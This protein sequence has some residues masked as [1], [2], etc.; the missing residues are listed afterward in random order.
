MQVAKCA[1]R[2]FHLSVTHTHAHRRTTTHTPHL[3]FPRTLG[4]LCFSA[5]RSCPLSNQA[6]G[7]VAAYQYLVLCSRL[8]WLARTG[9]SGVREVAWAPRE[10]AWPADHRRRAADW[11]SRRGWPRERAGGCAASAGPGGWQPLGTFPHA[12]SRDVTAASLRLPGPLGPGEQREE[13]CGWPRV[14][15]RRGQ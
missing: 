11:S 13:T 10:L 5:P 8:L 3:V 7:S 4:S 1:C 9:R 2:S 15:G 14:S 6:P 12:P